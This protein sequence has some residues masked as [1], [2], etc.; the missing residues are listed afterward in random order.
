[1]PEEPGV[2]AAPTTVLPVQSAALGPQFTNPGPSPA[3]ARP[4][5]LWW[6]ARPVRQPVGWAV[7]RKHEEQLCHLLLSD[8]GVTAASVA[9]PGS[10][11]ACRVQEACA[12]PVAPLAGSREMFW[13]LRQ[14]CRVPWRPRR[15]RLNHIQVQVA[16]HRGRETG[17]RRIPDPD[18]APPA[19]RTGVRSWVLGA[20]RSPF[21]PWRCCGSRLRRGEALLCFC[22]DRTSGIL[23]YFSRKI[24]TAKKPQ[25]KTKQKKTLSLFLSKR[26]SACMFSSSSS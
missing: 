16:E 20:G 4:E 23:E 17:P 15:R 21:R 22:V 7:P 10:C 6:A 13:G 24:I 11:V 8:P 3:A 14:P 9:A 2:P 12:E 18:A 1:M 19:E 25:N 26:I 5:L